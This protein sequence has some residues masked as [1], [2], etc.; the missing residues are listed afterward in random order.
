MNRRVSFIHR[1]AVSGFFLVSICFGQS[2]DYIPGTW[3]ENNPGGIGCPALA[4]YSNDSPTMFALTPIGVSTSDFALYI[5][6]Q[7]MQDASTGK[8]ENDFPVYNLNPREFVSNLSFTLEGTGSAFV[9]WIESKHQ[10][11]E[12]SIVA[13]T[14]SGAG[15]RHHIL[16]NNL[17]KDAFAVSSTLD[18]QGNPIVAWSEGYFQTDTSKRRRVNDYLQ[19]SY[20]P[21]YP[22]Q[23]QNYSDTA[24]Y[25]KRWDGTTWQDIGTPLDGYNPTL[26]LDK[27]DVPYLSYIRTAATGY[28]VV[29]VYWDGQAWQ[30]IGDVLT[31]NL[32]DV[33]RTL[34]FI[35]DNEGMP[36]IAFIGLSENEQPKLFIKRWNGT[37]WK[38]LGEDSVV[39]D[40]HNAFDV[41]LDY[42]DGK[43]VVATIEA[44]PQTFDF[45]PPQLLYVKEWNGGS[46]QLLGGDLVSS[47]AACPVIQVDSQGNLY[48]AW[49]QIVSDGHTAYTSVQISHFVRE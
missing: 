34:S 2:T 31:Q 48:V 17:G 33:S 22:R 27:K 32:F 8:W 25:V 7:N 5:L 21:R 38:S 24:T 14:R 15:E 36:I 29:V 20:Y 13:G 12:P 16:S 37:A 6:Q 40:G 9:T 18:K 26:V 23:E 47:G 42:R 46:W 28:E 11:G 4:L 10:Y 45:E 43:L 44:K 41:S 49:S 3:V 30:Q 19:Q 1:L 35:L 39:V